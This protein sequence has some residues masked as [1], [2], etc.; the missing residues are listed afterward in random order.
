MAAY[1]IVPGASEISIGGTSTVHAIKGSAVDVNGALEADLDGGELVRSLSGRIEVPVAGLRSGN[2]LQDGELQRR[3]DA[4]RYPRIVGEVRKAV[5]LGEDGL[6]R[7]EGDV[8]FHGVA[9][10]VED[11]VVVRADGDRLTLEGE[12]V[13]DI[14]DFGVKPPRILMLRVD[15]MV[16]VR[17]RLVAELA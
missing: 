11:T 12:H 2:P 6:F 15:P 5:P 1:T 4:R 3:V 8:T 7:V 17:I 16:K 10:A 9:R 14:R 13:F